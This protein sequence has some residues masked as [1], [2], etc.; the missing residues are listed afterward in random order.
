MHDYD[1]DPSAGA[2]N[3]FTVDSRCKPTILCISKIGLWQLYLQHSN[4]RLGPQICQALSSLNGGCWLFHATLAWMSMEV[5]C[6]PSSPPAVAP[7][8][9]SQSGKKKSEKKLLAKTESVELSK[10]PLLAMPRDQS[11]EH[12]L[13]PESNSNCKGPGAGGGSTR[14]GGRI[15]ILSCL[16]RHHFHWSLHN[17]K[18][19]REACFAFL[20][21][22]WVRDMLPKVTWSSCMS[23]LPRESPIRVFS[24]KQF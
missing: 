16:L 5:S 4:D 20:I 21:A 9:E 10:S 24:E 3:V 6:D 19:T 18:A 11:C 12:L 13:I 8:S 23:V 14:G 2:T 7:L 22:W 17:A 1:L 15:A